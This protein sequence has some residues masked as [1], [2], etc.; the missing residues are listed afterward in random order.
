MKPVMGI[1]YFFKIS[2]TTIN[3]FSTTTQTFV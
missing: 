2:L 3:Y 1:N